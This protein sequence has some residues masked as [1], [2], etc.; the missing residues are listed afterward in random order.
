[1]INVI[2][3]FRCVPSAGVNEDH[4][5]SP[6][7]Y[8]S[9][10]TEPR[11]FFPVRLELGA[12]AKTGSSALMLPS[13]VIII[14]SRRTSLMDFEFFLAYS[15]RSLCSASVRVVCTTFILHHKC[16]MRNETYNLCCMSFGRAH[17][18]LTHKRTIALRISWFPFQRTLKALVGC[19]DLNQSL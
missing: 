9:W 10:S 7:R 18:R 4:E 2:F 3:H 8:L 12:S 16:K 5:F 15:S 14:A 13:T 11:S 1:V 6:Y 19:A 17:E